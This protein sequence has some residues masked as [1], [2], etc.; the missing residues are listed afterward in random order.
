MIVPHIV[1]RTAVAPS[2]DWPDHV[3]LVLRRIYA[4]RGVTAYE[5]T[6]LR[7]AGLLPPD[8]LGGIDAASTLLA[9]AIQN[10]RRIVIVGDFDC[11]G[12]TGTAVGVRGMRLLGAR[13]VMY[14]V[15]HRVLHGYGL[16][17]ALVE[18]M[19]P[20]HPTWS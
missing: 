13:N 16:T 4:A 2:G 11:D 7:L 5:G 1:R 19:R 18:V 10:D 8:T 20:L 15:P 17:P 9:Y 6:Q 12:A 3:P 14:Q